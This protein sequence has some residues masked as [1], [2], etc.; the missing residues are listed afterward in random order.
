MQKESGR[1]WKERVLLALVGAAVLG[2]ILGGA[3]YREDLSTYFHLHGW[4]AASAE[5]L[6]R[7]FARSAH[8]GDPAAVS[9]LDGTRAKAVMT[10]GKLTGID[11]MGERGPASVRI[12]QLVPTAE[13][14]STSLRIRPISRVFGV[15]VEYADGHWAEFA[16]DRTPAGLRIVDVSDSLGDRMLPQRD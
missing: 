14:K 12:E 7:D 1:R 15:A 8:E 9:A 2:T 4:D 5:K 3:Y 6:V 16:V 13:V 11:H 10:G